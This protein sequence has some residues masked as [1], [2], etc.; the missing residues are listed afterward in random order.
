MILRGLRQRNQNTRLAKRG[1][2][3]NTSRSRSVYDK[4]SRGVSVPD[5]VFLKESHGMIIRKV[6]LRYHRFCF[7]FNGFEIRFSGLMDNFKLIERLLKNAEKHIVQTLGAL[8]A[9]HNQQDWFAA[10]KLE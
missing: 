6:L 2:F 7:C 10:H 1:D 4:V 3:K 8:R 5:F 9:A